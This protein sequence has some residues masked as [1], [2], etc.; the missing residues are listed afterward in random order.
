MVIRGEEFNELRRRLFNTPNM[1]MFAQ[2]RLEQARMT[3][4]TVQARAF[5]SNMREIDES[6]CK[7]VI[8][9]AGCGTP[10]T[11]GCLGASC[12]FIK[13]MVFLFFVLCRYE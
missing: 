4:S 8:F 13:S 2:E 12:G 7:D 11:G 9:T 5:S 6:A 1:V 10:L 3:L